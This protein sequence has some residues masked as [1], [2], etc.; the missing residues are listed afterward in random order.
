MDSRFTVEAIGDGRVF[1]IP[2]I[3]R[4][5]ILSGFSTID[6]NFPEKGA[7]GL[8][9]I[10]EISQSPIDSFLSSNLFWVSCLNLKYH[11]T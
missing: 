6:F 10:K 4:L 5:Q 7:I 2:R 1:R 11:E 9:E 8:W 3:Q